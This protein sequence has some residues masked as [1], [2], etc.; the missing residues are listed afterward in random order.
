MKLPLFIFLSVFTL[1]SSQPAHA[2]AVSAGGMQAPAALEC[3][4][5]DPER[6]TEPYNFMSFEIGR[7]KSHSLVRVDLRSRQALAVYNS[8]ALKLSNSRGKTTLSGEMKLFDQFQNSNLRLTM[9][10]T[11]SLSHEEYIALFSE[12]D[13]LPHVTFEKEALGYNAK[14]DFQD[15]KLS[16]IC[17][18][19]PLFYYPMSSR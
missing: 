11:Q 5:L 16:G 17:S 8:R 12:L 1:V 3:L 6:P 15:Q 9:D 13:R 4:F 7:S 14:L 19:G 2:G 18:E 10:K